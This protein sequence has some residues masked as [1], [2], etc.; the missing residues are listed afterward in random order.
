MWAQIT[1]TS[2][3]DHVESH[4][5]TTDDWA[6]EEATT[7]TQRSLDLLVGTLVVVVGRTTT[8]VH[9]GNIRL[10]SV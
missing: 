6:L 2:A 4:T 8:L 3:D 1:L 7:I 9:G 10:A 5:G